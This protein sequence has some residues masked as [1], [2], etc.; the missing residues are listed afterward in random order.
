MR[1]LCFFAPTWL[2]KY[3]KVQSYLGE[4]PDRAE[5]VITYYISMTSVVSQMT[6]MN[7]NP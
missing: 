2:L 6:I 5:G 3:D 4:V 1:Q 7:L